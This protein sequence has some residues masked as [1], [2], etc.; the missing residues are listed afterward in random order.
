[1]GVATCWDCLERNRKEKTGGKAR[2]FIRV[3]ETSEIQRER[4]QV[5]QDVW[6]AHRAAINMAINLANEQKDNPEMRRMARA[7]RASG[8]LLAEEVR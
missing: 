8:A 1:M 5:G 7:L 2:K 3:T 4:K 6:D